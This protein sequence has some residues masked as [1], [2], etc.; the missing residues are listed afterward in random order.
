MKEGLKPPYQGPYRVIRRTEK[1]F[2]VDLDGDEKTLSIDQLEPAFLPVEHAV[3]TIH[4]LTS[5]SVSNVKISKRVHF[6]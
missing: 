2:T 6:V 1:H 5:E 3:E 4:L